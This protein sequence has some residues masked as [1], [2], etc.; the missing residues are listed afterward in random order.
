MING[1]A[2]EFLA[3]K[4]RILP[5]GTGEKKISNSFFAGFGSQPIPTQNTWK[6][7]E[8]DPQGCYLGGYWHY[9]LA[10]T[11]D[12]TI[13]IR[14]YFLWPGLIFFKGYQTDLLAHHYLVMFCFSIY[15]LLLI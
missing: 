1:D 13:I 11:S 15:L 8:I 14:I 4:N 12:M 6:F 9:L 7:P 2:V 3:R 10:K 5:E